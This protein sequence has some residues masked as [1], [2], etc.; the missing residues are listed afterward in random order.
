MLAAREHSR[1]ELRR[2]LGKYH[3]DPE[4]IE[5]VLS[6]LQSSNLQSDARFAEHFVESRISKG[7]GPVRIR[8]ELNERG[9]PGELIETALEPY[10][11]EWLELLTRVRNDKF[12]GEKPET[13]KL[14][15]KQVR[16]LESRGFPGELIRVLLLD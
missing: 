13:G 11:D 12:G 7:Q 1:E 9:V 6:D 3:R 10:A 8:M 5:Q 16:F 14:L 4:L 15:G 2:K